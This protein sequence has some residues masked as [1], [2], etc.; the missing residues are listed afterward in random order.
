[1]LLQVLTDRSSIVAV[2]TPYSVVTYSVYPNKAGDVVV[3]DIVRC[4]IIKKLLHYILKIPPY[5][6]TSGKFK[7]TGFIIVSPDDR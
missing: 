3:S 5:S 6:Y 1:V 2:E 7:H 4:S